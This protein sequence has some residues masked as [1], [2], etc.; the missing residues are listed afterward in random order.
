MGDGCGGPV[1]SDERRRRLVGWRKGCDHML[2]VRAEA[3]L[4]CGEPSMWMIS[5]M[6]NEPTVCWFV[7]LMILFR[8]DSA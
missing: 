3:R 8:C 5:G 1:G 6:V 2:R 4:F 7:M